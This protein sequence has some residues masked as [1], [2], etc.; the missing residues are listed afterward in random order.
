MAIGWLAVLQMVPWSDVIK[1]APRVADGAK[2]LWHTVAK[3][4]SLVPPADTVISVQQSPEGQAIAALR[5]HV[6]ALESATHDL[7]E[8][9]LASSE[10]IKA[11]AEQ[12]TQLIRRAETN[13]IRLLALAGLTALVAVIA[14]VALTL[15]L[16]R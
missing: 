1:N 7:H 12:N 14:V 3:K 2:K 4:P 9:M 13:R 11:L 5:A 10:L 15:A 8:Q 6:L 16:A